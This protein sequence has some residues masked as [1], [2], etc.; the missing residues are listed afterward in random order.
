MG[1]INSCFAAEMTCPDPQ[2]SQLKEGKIPFP[3]LKNPFSAYDPPVAEL[4]SFIRANILVAGGIGRGVVC[5]YAFSKGTY[6]IWWQ[7]NVKIPAPTNT[8]WLS[9][10]GGFECPAVRVSDCIFNAAM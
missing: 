7:G 2:L 4:S 1:S 8:N 3:W 6:S 9:S 10:L 5:H